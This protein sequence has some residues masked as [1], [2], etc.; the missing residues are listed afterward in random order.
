MKRQKREWEV[1]LIEEFPFLKQSEDGEDG[2]IYQKYGFECAEGWYEL[3]RDCCRKIMDCYSEAGAEIDFVPVQIKEKWGTLRFYYGYADAPCG[4]AAFDFIGSGVSIR[5]E[6]GLKGTLEDEKARLRHN[7]SQIIKEAEAMSS[8]TCEYCGKEGTLR[9]DLPW[10]RTL[11]D[12]CYKKASALVENGRKKATWRWLESGLKLYKDELYDL[13]YHQFKKAEELA[14]TKEGDA[15]DNGYLGVALGHIFLIAKD[16]TCAYKY[17]LQ[18]AETGNIAGIYM[19]AEMYK[20]GKGVEKDLKKYKSIIKTLAREVSFHSG[21][22]ETEDCG[23][24]PKVDW[25]IEDKVFLAKICSAY[26][27][28]LEEEG[29]LKD[30][31]EEYNLAAELMNEYHNLYG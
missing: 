24:Y 22:W 17:F 7:I 25:Y 29:R 13:A 26:G 14:T 19:V 9:R 12:D 23:F 30:A 11:C 1:K 5:F 8:H 4:L 15:G 31:R 2:T 16:Y 3:L 28:L 18:S 21:D 20:T 6:P 10:V 27:E